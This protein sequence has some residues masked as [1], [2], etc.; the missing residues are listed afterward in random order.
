MTTIDV[1]RQLLVAGMNAEKQRR[2]GNSHVLVIGAGG[3]ATTALS[4]L[5]MS[6]IQRLTIVDFDTIEASN[7]HRQTLYTPDDI[8]KNKAETAK[9][10]LLQ[11]APNADIQSITV[12]LDQASLSAMIDHYDVVLDC[13]DSLALSYQL[14]DIAVCHKKAVIFANAIG[15]MGQLFT[16]IPTETPFSCFRCAWPENV[17][18]PDNHDII[19]VMGPVPGVLGSLQALQAIKYLSTFCPLENSLLYHVDLR[20]LMVQKIDVPINPACRH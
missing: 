16:M 7:L 12:A 18:P 11:R 20:A 17:K 14:N 8:G 13:T 1:S 19:G 6:G 2:L 3:L 15:M 9:N 4:Y 5:V 10:Y